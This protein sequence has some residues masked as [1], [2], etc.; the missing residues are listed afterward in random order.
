MN[1]Y[2]FILSKAYLTDQHRSELKTKR[3]FTDDTITK[4][5]FVSGGEYLL[6]LEA[7]LLQ[8]FTHEDL[9]SSGV[10]ISTGKGEQLNP[11]LTENR[12]IIPYLSKTGD[13]VYLRPHKL[14]LGGVPLEVY[15]EANLSEQNIILTEGEFKAAAAVQ[16]GFCAIAVPGIS[17]FSGENLQRLIA[18]LNDNKVRRV[19]IMFDNEV[20]DDPRFKDRYKE[21]PAHRYDTQFYAYF[22]AKEL[23][24]EKFDTRVAWLPDGWRVN[25]KIDIDGAL[26]Q[27]KTRDDIARVI[28]DAKTHTEFLNDL[29]GE[30][31]NICLRKNK[32]KQ[33][34]SHIRVEFGHYVATRRRSKSE[35]DE[36][37]SNFTLKLIA[38]H[39]TQEGMIREIQFANEF[40]QTFRTFSIDP[41]HMA[42]PE[43]FTVFCLNHGNFIWRGNKEDLATIWEQEFLNDDGRHILEPDRIGWIED[44]KVWLFGNVAITAEGKEIRPDKNHVFWFEKRGLKPVSL[45]IANGKVQVSEGI[46]YLDLTSQNPI[47]EMRTRLAESIGVNEAALCI[48]WITAVLFLE[49]VFELYRCF[50]F[51]FLTGKRGCGKSTVGEWLMDAFGLENAGKMASDTTQVGLQR[52][53]S[54]YSSLPVFVDEYRNTKQITMKNG[55]LRNAYNRQS[56]GKG[57]KANFG[58]REARIRGTLLISGE[59]TPEDNALLTRCILV[60]LSERSRLQNHFAWFMANRMKFAAHTIDI[61]RRKKDLTDKFIQTLNKAKAYF[62]AQGANDRTAINYAVVA[63]GYVTVFG[64]QGEGAFEQW[65][66]RETLRVQTEYHN[67]QAINQFLD[68]LVAMRTRGLINHKYWLVDDTGIYLY[69]HGLYSA[70]SQEYRKTH[71]DNP[72]KASAIRDYLKEEDGFL[73]LDARKRIDGIQQRCVQFDREKAPEAIRSLVDEE[74]AAVTA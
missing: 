58:V 30:A 5:K 6:A 43:G 40:G 66:T 59:E 10:F 7:K 48:G 37:I 41:E 63:A 54:Y 22:M 72:F 23:D 15:Q 16:M 46:P 51:L 50:P 56:A 24:R 68:D 20:K 33:F 67:E 62:V 44:E 36:I 19:T 35:W 1:I 53:L 31:K 17:S 21:N 2:S 73:A 27:G 4:C 29:P 49:E 55:F 69:F 8:T 42:G 52:Y 39:Q 38:T 57:I 32:M 3:G 65:I 61:L 18:L 70:W 64:D 13:P 12:I 45:G 14:G 9:I 34:R 28:R 11:I 71:G 74:V 60:V 26:A 47:Y 25:G